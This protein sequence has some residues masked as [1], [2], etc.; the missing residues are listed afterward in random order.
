MPRRI[1]FSVLARVL[2]VLAAVWLATAGGWNLLWLLLVPALAWD[3]LK[4]FR[5]D[6]VGRTPARFSEPG[7]HRVVLQVPGSNPILV[8]REIRRTRGLG[9]L[10]AKE[11]VESAPVVVAEGLSEQSA[12]LVAD[13]L[14]AAGARALAAP[15]GEM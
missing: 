12:E 3:I 2:A 15:I 8:I 14:R 4:V 11:L 10:E 5:P 9:L 7:R 13:R 1:L 6:L